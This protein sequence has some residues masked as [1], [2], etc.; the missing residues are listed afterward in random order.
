MNSSNNS[1]KKRGP[2]TTIKNVHVNY[3]LIMSMAMIMQFYVISVKHGSILNVNILI[4]LITNIYKVVRNHGIA[5][6]VSQ[7]SFH[8]II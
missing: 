1:S 6:L 8:L 2:D 7:C 3:A 4:I 5:A